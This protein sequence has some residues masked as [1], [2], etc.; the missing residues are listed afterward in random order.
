MDFIRDNLFR[1]GGLELYPNSAEMHYWRVARKF[2]PFCFRQIK[3]AGFRIVST[4]VP[5]NHHEYEQGKF[6]FSGETDPQR[7]LLS[8][9]KEC[10]QVGF[11]VILR[12]GPWICSEWK[13]GGHP[14]YLF[15]SNLLVARNAEDEPVH[16]GNCADVEK[17]LAPCYAHPEFLGHVRRYFTAL[18]EA[19]REHLHPDGN[20][21]LI[22]LD[23]E[24]SHCFAGGV[25]DA[26]YH[27]I[28]TTKLYP[29]FL[30]DRYKDIERLNSIYL[31]DLKD[32][33]ECAP[34][35]KLEVKTDRDL[36][37]YFDWIEFKERYLATF[38]VQLRKM[39]TDLNVRTGFC[40]NIRWGSDF[41][42]PTNWPMFEKYSGF[43]GIDIYWPNDYYEVQRY[44]RYLQTTS[45]MPWSPE[46]M[47]GLWTDDPDGSRRFNPI[48]EKQQQFLVLSSLAA[49]LRGM[50]FYMFVERDHWYG[51]PVTNDGRR[52]EGWDF[53]KKL[54]EILN[55]NEYFETEK[56]NN[57]GVVHYQP[58][59][60]YSYLDPDKPFDH[61][62]DLC[63]QVLPDLCT[64]LGQ[65]G[66]DYTIVDPALP[67]S[68]EKHEILFIPIADYLDDRVAKFYEQ[69]AGSGKKLVFFGVPPRLDLLMRKSEVFAAAFGVRSAHHLVVEEMQWGEL[70]FRSRAIGRLQLDESWEPAVRD[71]RG[72]VYAARR[73]FG[74]G[75]VWFLG[76]DPASNFVPAKRLFLESLLDELGAH[77]PVRV[78][79]P[80]IEAYIK[81]SEKHRFLFLINPDK[82][83]REEFRPTVRNAT[84]T[85]DVKLLKLHADSITFVN[86]FTGE[87]A[88]EP[89]V[90]V[91]EGVQFPIGSGEAQM[92]EV[93]PEYGL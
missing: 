20:V 17:G 25:F 41:V 55:D 39:L 61:I 22:Q 66:V 54:N 77:R 86:L 70:R 63:R 91:R 35:R 8:F 10:R 92:F 34:P 58:Y 36:V 79:E 7:D 45:V 18:I 32:F 71:S 49:G 93:I 44:I 9:L 56:V 78:E 28:V 29:R 30:R 14:D 67:E 43:A 42:A 4:Y 27:Q 83:V 16:A 2:W 12:P 48:P 52:A 68:L 60:R 1:P 73:Q 87:K 90:A 62:K 5:W 19:I 85:L 24:L 89:L 59:T 64:D 31:T 76:F 26:D 72:N 75:T 37:K 50:N 69:L 88:N 80:A 11:R 40:T 6:D 46:F 81:A 65:L 47:A 51:S 13:N 57:V 74:T 38:L 82:S 15:E 3:E 84:L 23:N 33:S 21:F 53:Y